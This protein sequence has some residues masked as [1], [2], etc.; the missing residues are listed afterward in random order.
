MR[1]E[2]D[3]NATRVNQDAQHKVFVE[4]KD[5]QEIDP[6]VIKELL[7]N[8]N[9]TAVDVSTM[10]GCDN[11]RSAAQALIKEYPS[12][13]FLIDRDDQDQQ[14]V[15][16]SWQS[17][18][19]PDDYNMLIWHKRE[20]ENY[21]IDPDYIKKSPRL[22]PQINIEER[23]LDEC[24]LRIFLDAANLTLY[25]IKRELGKTFP[26]RHFKNP[27]EFRDQNAGTLKLNGLAATI[28]DRK[29][30]VTTVLEGNA[31]NQ[32]YLE[33]IQELSGGTI[34]L[35]YG[36]G[37]WLE[38]MSG[39]EIFRAIANQCFEVEGAQGQLVTGKE[40]NKII[41]KELTRLPLE[42]QPND[43]QRLVSL[44]QNKVGVF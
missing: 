36:S 31:V 3:V 37:S 5:N 6:I 15:D 11:V 32:R 33:F 8:N 24:N 18:P 30:S 1:L 20:L 19:N 13:Y 34:P 28:D 14:T 7:D 26:I 41:A 42:Q 25:S 43:F 22:K 16:K 2:S 23:I 44:L 27:D 39:K 9:L 17:F 4:G 29:I 12:H 35:Q 10:G 21:F 40:K 38:R